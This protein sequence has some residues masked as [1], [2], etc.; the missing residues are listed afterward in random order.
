MQFEVLF[1][2]AGLNE[3]SKEGWHFKNT[4]REETEQPF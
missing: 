4:M 3:R 2:V 1:P